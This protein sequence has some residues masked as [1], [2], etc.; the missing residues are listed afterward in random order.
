VL[1]KNWINFNLYIISSSKIKTIEGFYLESG[2]LERGCYALNTE[3]CDS[4]LDFLS[5]EIYQNFPKVCIAIDVIKRFSMLYN[6]HIK[7]ID[8]NLIYIQKKV[9]SSIVLLIK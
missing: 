3:N 5:Q 2:Y 6:L 7:Q 8:L 1:E 4:M 9:I